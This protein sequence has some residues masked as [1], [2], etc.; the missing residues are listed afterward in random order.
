[1]MIIAAYCRSLECISGSL[2]LLL[3]HYTTQMY[4]VTG[5]QPQLCG[6]L[7]QRRWCNVSAGELKSENNNSESPLS[8]SDW[9]FIS[10][11]TVLYCYL[12][13]LQHNPQ[14]MTLLTLHN[15]TLHYIT[16]HYITLHY[17]TLHYST[18]E[19]LNS[20]SERIFI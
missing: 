1:M 5:V 6:R 15:V 20:K 3:S 13:A 16:L 9:P 18:K 10:L 7:D 17:I 11:C 12:Q 4:H 19:S 14:A 8:R 2:L